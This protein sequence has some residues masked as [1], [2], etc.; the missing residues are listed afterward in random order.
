[1]ATSLSYF[2]VHWTIFAAMALVF[3]PWSS[4]QHF[5]NEVG[6]EAFLNSIQ[7]EV[8]AERLA[9]QETLIEQVESVD[10]AARN[11]IGAQ[12]KNNLFRVTPF[13]NLIFM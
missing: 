5:E 10:S 2:L 11:F 4:S 8:E 3:A 7:R 12:I 1:M 6:D 9:A 13:A